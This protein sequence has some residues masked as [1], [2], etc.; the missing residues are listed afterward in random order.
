MMLRI[1]IILVVRIKY[2][3]RADQIVHTQAN[4]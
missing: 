3:G 2:I 4:K 1:W